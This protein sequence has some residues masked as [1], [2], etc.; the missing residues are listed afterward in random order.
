MCMIYK[1]WFGACDWYFPRSPLFGW[2]AFV[3]ITCHLKPSYPWFLLELISFVIIEHMLTWNCRWT[4]RFFV[5]RIIAHP[6]KTSTVSPLPWRTAIAW[7]PPGLCNFRVPSGQI[8]RRG[9]WLRPCWLTDVAI[10]LL[11]TL[12]CYT[13]VVWCFNLLWNTLILLVLHLLLLTS[14]F[15]GPVTHWP[16]FREHFHAPDTA[17]LRLWV[18][19]TSG[20]TI[21]S[22]AFA[23]TAAAGMLGTAGRC[24]C[25]GPSHGGCQVGGPLTAPA[26][27][28]RCAERCVGDSSRGLGRVLPG[29][30][31]WNHMGITWKYGLLHRLMGL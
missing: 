3:L 30:N 8:Q 29:E 2:H 4:F 23:T 20:A 13:V 19:W 22:P 26:F 17:C 12:G 7:Q 11:L 1:A 27:R 15:Y 6:F 10:V 25:Q 14:P 16:L 18:A 28:S 21:W 5:H 24:C 9:S 31:A